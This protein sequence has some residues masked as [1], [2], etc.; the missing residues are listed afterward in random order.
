MRKVQIKFYFYCIL[1]KDKGLFI[2]F[3]KNA[4][5]KIICI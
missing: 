4:Q 2:S 1:I 3:T 5:K